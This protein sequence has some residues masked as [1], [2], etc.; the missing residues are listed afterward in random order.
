MKKFIQTIKNIIAIE[1]LRN[2]IL[3][4]LGLILIYR[5]GAH[6]VIP[7]V[8]PAAMPSIKMRQAREVLL[9]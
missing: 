5:L 4:T 6:V 3:A 9:P 8:D 7:G 2:K 1:D